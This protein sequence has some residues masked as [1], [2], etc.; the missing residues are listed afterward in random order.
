LASPKLYGGD[1]ETK[2]MTAF[3]A[4]EVTIG[5]NILPATSF[6]PKTCYALVRKEKREAKP[7]D[8]SSSEM[9]ARRCAHH[10]VAHSG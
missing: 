8:S 1:S 2:D 7:S 6:A 3:I 9:V 5:G 10:A 4:D